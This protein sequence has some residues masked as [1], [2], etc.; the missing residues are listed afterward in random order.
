LTRSYDATNQD[1]AI[2]SG[3]WSAPSDLPLDANGSEVNYVDYVVDYYYKGNFKERRRVP[4]Q[5]GVSNYFDVFNVGK[6][7]GHY[8][9]NVFS[10]HNG[11]K[12]R[13][14]ISES[15]NIPVSGVFNGIKSFNKLF[16]K[17]QSL[18]QEIQREL[19]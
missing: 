17:T 8:S 7:Y 19:E 13:N 11:V 16:R 3:D 2:I 18:Q 1:Q 9:V 5:S 14:Y 4:G 10:E 12:S 6:D 15:I